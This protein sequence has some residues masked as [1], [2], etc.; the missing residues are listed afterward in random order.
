MFE[1]EHEVRVV[2]DMEVEE[3]IAGYRLGWDPD[4]SLQLIRVHPEADASFMQTVSKTVEHYAPALNDCV[5]WS[6]MKER[7]PL[8]SA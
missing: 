4:K 8:E 7:P 2:R 1:Y 5:A 6:G 3:D